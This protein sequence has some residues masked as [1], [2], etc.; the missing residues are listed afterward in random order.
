MSRS[1]PNF[2]VAH[3][4][5]TLLFAVCATCL[6]A[7]D[8]K[9][10]EQIFSILRAAEHGVFNMG[11]SQGD[12][13]KV[14][15]AETGCEVFELNYD[16][17][18]GSAVGIWTKDFSAELEALSAD[19]I[20]VGV[21]V[22][23]DVRHDLILLSVE[24]KG[25]AAIQT[26]H[27]DLKPGRNT[28]FKLV[29][30]NRIGDLHEA[31]FV[32]Q[33]LEGQ[34]AAGKLFLA[35]DFEKRS[36]AEIIRDSAWAKAGLLLATSFAAWLLAAL[37]ARLFRRPASAQTATPVGL[38]R[39]FTL[40]LGAVLTA[41]LALYIHKLGGL[42]P[43]AAGF[44]FLAVA[45]GGAALADF[46]KYGLTRNHLTPSECF[47]SLFLSGLLAVTSSSQVVLQAP[48]DWNQLL[49]KSQFTAA[50]AFAIY[51]AAHAFVLATSGRSLRAVS[52]CLIV[53]TPYLVGW[54][55]LLQSPDLMHSMIQ[56]LTAGTLTSAPVAL[57]IVGR[58]L[59]VLVFNELVTSAIG[60]ATKGRLLTTFRAHGAI[61]LV[62][63]GVVL[64][65]NI[66]DFGSTQAVAALHPALR[67]L[68]GLLATILSQAGLW[69]EVYLITGLIMDSTHGIG[70][71]ATSARSHALVGMGK[72]MAYSGVLIAILYSVYLFVQTRVLQLFMLAHPLLSGVVL[73][74]AVFPLLKTIIETFDGSQGFFGRVRYNYRRWPLYFR[75]TV[76]G[77]GL[78]FG[79]SQGV[80]RCTTPDRVQFGL[81]L[82]LAAS[83]GA[84]LARDLIYAWQGRGHIQ[85]WR[86]YFA[87]A[88]MGGFVGSA[89]AFYLDAS[90]VPV[91]VEKIKLYVSAGL[92]PAA[93]DT[94]PL[95]NKWGH[96]QLG[97]YTGGVKLLFNEAL[98]GVINWSVAAWLF[99]INRTFLEALFQ[100][101]KA[102]I[103]FFFSR[104]GLMDLVRHMIQVLRW[105]LWMSPIIF[106]FLRMMGEATWYNQD[107]ALRTLAAIYQ[108]ATLSPENFQAWSVQMFVYVLAFDLVRIL[109][110]MDHMGLRVATL[111]NL[112]FIGMDRLDER[113]A[114]FLGPSATQRCIPEAIKRFTTWAPLLIPFYLPRG[115]SW[116]YA[117]TT[118]E[119]LAAASKKD[120]WV[121]RLESLSA[122]ESLL[123]VAA[124]GAAATAI[125]FALRKLRERNARKRSRTFE[126]A[127]REYRVTARDNGEIFSQVSSKRHDVSR[128]SY[129]TMDPAGRILFL[130]DAAKAAHEPGRAWPTTGNV[131]P[132]KHAA[133]R[134][135]CRDDSLQVSN[136]AHGIRTAIDIR[137]P[138]ADSTAEIWT[139]TLE[140]LT[141]TPRNLKLVPYLEWVLDR[142]ESDRGHTLYNRLFPEMEYAQ[143]GHAILAWQRTSKAMG[144]LATD[145]A[146]EGF[147]ISR[148]DFIGRA[149]TVWAPR[150]LETLAFLN[151]HDT[152]PCPTFDPVAS[153][154]TSVELAP[155][156]SRTVRILIGYAKNRAG[157]LDLVHKH[158]PLQPA[159]ATRAAKS[160]PRSPLIGH[161]EIL[162]GTPRSYSSFMN[163]GNTLRVHTPFTPR[164]YDHALANARGHYITVTNRGLHTSASGNSQQNRLTP[165]WPDTVTRELPGEAIYLFDPERKEWFCPTFHP[166]NDKT[167]SYETDFSV[168]GTAVFRMTRGSLSTELN[169]FVPPDENTGIYLLTVRNN[170][171]V[172]RRLRVA[173]YF[174][175][176]LAGQPEHSGPLQVRYDKSLHALFYANPRNAFRQG[177][178]FAAM[179]IPA[180]RVVTQRGQF[181][182]A[183]R[184]VDRPSFV[185]HGEA[186]ASPTLDTRTIAG[187]LG[188]LDVPAGGEQTV[189]I[190]LGQTDNRKQAVALLRKY[191]HA[192]AALTT[193][194][195]TRSW[196]MNL[197]QTTRIETSDPHFD[198]LQNWL[199]YQALAERIWARRGFYQ[200]SGAYGFRDQLQ[201]SVN[202]IWMTPDLAR[203]QIL[204]HASQQFLEGDVV[205]WF[206]TM[207][208]GRTGFANRSHASD[209]LLWL[210]WGVVEYVRMS[211]DESILEE[212]TSYLQSELPFEPLPKNKHGW[213][214]IY[215]RSARADSVYRHCM[216]SI[217]LVLQKR[218]GAHGLPLIGTGDWNDG[219]DEIGS[220]GRGESVWLGFFLYYI[221][222]NVVDLVERRDGV[223]RK[224]YYV[225]QMTSL[226][227][228]LEA[229]WRKD[230]YLRAIHDDGTEIGV[231]GSGVWEIDAL[232]GAWAVMSGIN[233][234][235]ARTVFDTTL[236]VLERGNVI[237]LGW[238]ALREDTEPY[239]GRS[240]HYPE[241]VRENGMYCHG[242]QWLIR[243]ARLLSEQ[244][245]RDG[246]T[247]E[248]AYYRE[249]A[250]RLWRKI[251]PVAHVTPE[252]IEN[253]GGQ[254]NKQPA[255]LL[256]TFD[257]GRMIWNGYTGAAGWM[258][259]QAFEGVVGATLSRNE[260]VLPDDLFEPR[261]TMRVTRVSR[262]LEAS[263]LGGVG[264]HA[265]IG[266]VS[267]P[268]ASIPLA[269]KDLLDPSRQLRVAQNRG[270]GKMGV[271]IRG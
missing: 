87:D 226:A 109:V 216:K 103:C 165:D 146:P 90:Q 265:M 243:A 176:V 152:P 194:A 80:F 9:A 75:G 191:A 173:P 255:D 56:T 168:D 76:F 60:L 6:T 183:G 131:P 227:C 74:A 49:L 115:D 212:M 256:T 207:K 261:G 253:Y 160:P 232:T 10:A 111:V 37:A 117:W 126:I 135:E 188:T 78:A 247:A 139:V 69:A 127:N 158:L 77:F 96:I 134:I 44:R 92:A 122:A 206:H 185:E 81:A 231:E 30:W 251:A 150:A 213:G 85:S 22:P 28:F 104:A 214:A 179:S 57:D 4:L 5:R 141:D 169:V 17:S 246:K 264:H 184:G 66:A 219:L 35:L 16:A 142:P 7:S 235:R 201:D 182:G 68:A 83:A 52:G 163:Q 124:A 244:F 174:Q 93:Y 186:D 248:A 106:T 64:A 40:G 2:R 271:R 41:G 154:L 71:S 91:V 8:A 148:M 229:S 153:L 193:L 24:L 187:L 129:D 199:K 121:A 19:R 63:L 102:P 94:Y 143:A 133:A 245:A 132:A 211:G 23:D 241:G 262:V 114:R 3:A 166:L 110:W 197:M 140:N 14:T 105:G 257:P 249:T 180:E 116:D 144:I 25:S 48:A 72:G 236:R 118:S 39:D 130:V 47:R 119:A 43:D 13:E 239:L 107:G 225:E 18:A 21:T 58:L 164:P 162:P 67:S 31:V 259:R 120:T 101:D 198:N 234:E 155:K 181:F 138:D 42:T 189:A 11:P 45:V 268:A 70:P 145:I 196:W 269:E 97:A 1:T 266:K 230:R 100:R 240:S 156:A 192:E 99:A 195:A 270:A 267:V 36:L 123:L 62:S 20:R 12:V 98:A 86:V 254:P 54:L 215:H 61:V 151:A 29:D 228:A 108:H 175:I 217:D 242:V 50:I 33:P 112:S 252:E 46:M 250:Y 15:D 238:P 82:G 113:L 258:L 210:S 125:F 171:K 51:H 79:I 147:L 32:I 202:L 167:A 88:L 27:L 65:P 159:T 55:L 89:L 95:V 204:L 59:V 205:H 190:L 221:L 233:P 157:A 263:P 172:A 84:S 208:D 149:G 128:R 218:M 136:T 53:G 224:Q 203:K 200:T 161:G 209:N 220:E 260:M 177:P 237:L 178:A 34:S 223:L 222:K 73:G 170:D 38:A 26:I 137:L